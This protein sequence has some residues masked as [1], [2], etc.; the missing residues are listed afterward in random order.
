MPDAKAAAEALALAGD[1]QPAIVGSFG[2]PARPLD[3][4]SKAAEEWSSEA[5]RKPLDELVERL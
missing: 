2:Y 4:E 3:P 5:N 1:E